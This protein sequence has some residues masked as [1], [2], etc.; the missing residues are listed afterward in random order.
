MSSEP[1]LDVTVP[2][3]EVRAVALVLHGGREVGTTPVRARQLAVLRM[4]PFAT[5]LR[6]A[7]RDQALAVARLRYVVRGWNGAA[8]SPVG[9]VEWALGRLA[10]RFAHAPIALIGHS[11]GGRA[12]VYAAGHE[13]VR[14]VVGLAPWLERDDPSAQLAGRHVLFAHGQRD[15]VTS[16][17]ATAAWLRQADGRAASAS[18]VAVKG[19][20]HAML[21]RAPLWHALTA[22]YVL[23]V[24]CGVPLPDSPRSVGTDVAAK[25]LAGD[26]SLVV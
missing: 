10:E 26:A 14:A 23:A 15:R 20:G 8:R 9:D 21:R 24:L 1:V 22:R 2:P 17:K 3:G 16:P 11:M 7:G 25:V 6:R 12:A 5:A 18:F 4:A 19:E 13:S